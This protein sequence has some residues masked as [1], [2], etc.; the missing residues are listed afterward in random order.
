M[1]VIR[2]S[3]GTIRWM[4]VS[5]YLKRESEGG[6]KT[7]KQVVFTGEPFTA[8]NLRRMRDMVL[9]ALPQG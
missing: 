4:D 3:D 6:K 5:D 7:V 8:F 9:G 1:L 2:T